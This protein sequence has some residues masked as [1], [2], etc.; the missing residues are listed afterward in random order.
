[1]GRLATGYK[2]LGQ[3]ALDYIK[4]TDGRLVTYDELTRELYGPSAS[5]YRHRDL[6]RRVLHEARNLLGNTG[7]ER[8]QILTLSGQGVMWRPR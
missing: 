1:M 8:Y 2:R 3:V 7:R 5:T 6:V 4:T